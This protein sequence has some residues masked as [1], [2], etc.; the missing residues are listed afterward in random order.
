MA[1][2]RTLVKRDGQMKLI[3]EMVN[4]GR[5][6]VEGEGR[7]K[8]P[9]KEIIALVK[10]IRSKKISID[11]LNEMILNT[12]E[13]EKME[14][15]MRE[16]M[17]LDIMIDTDLEILEGHLAGLKLGRS[18]NE[19]AEVPA[20]EIEENRSEYSY[21]QRSSSVTESRDSQLSNRDVT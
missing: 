3:K 15:E 5:S 4:K 19:V 17:E 6:I 18:K 13:V 9:E 14:D 16:S 1:D 8:N 2:R 7:S 11:E 10:N 12:V 20:E 21:S